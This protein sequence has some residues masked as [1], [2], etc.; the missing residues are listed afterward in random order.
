MNSLKYILFL[1]MTS[2]TVISSTPYSGP[3]SDHFNGKTFENYLKDP[4]KKSFW[5]FVKMKYFDD[6]WP[7]WPTEFDKVKPVAPD[8]THQAKVTFINHATLLIQLDHQNILTDPIWS[9]RASPFS[10]AGPARVTEPG[11]KKE[12]LPKIDVIL[13]SHNHY[14][15]LD[16]E[17]LKYLSK[18]DRPLILIGLGNDVLL[19]ENGI[20]NVKTLDW[21]E[22]IEI[23]EIKY[24]FTPSQHWSARGLRDRNQTLWG[25]FWIEGSKKIYFAGDTGFG[26]HF[27]MIKS[28]LG[29]PDL[30]LLPIG[31]YEP[32]WFM[33]Y[34]HM[35]P[36][37]ALDT[38]HLLDAKTSIGIHFGT[39]RL[40]KEPYDAPKKDL[41]EAIKND[42][43]KDDSKFYVPYN[44]EQFLF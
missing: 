6:P 13:I 9:N 1:L 43:L 42:P 33:R 44:G 34:A 27:H 15:H 11:V 30:A 26:P 22:S 38:H 40:T 7:K 25:S 28:R 37:E 2:C 36:K 17:S 29:S 35:N 3:K 16:L 18:R 39:F 21:W 41:L 31:A 8:K 19:K 20:E 24:S 12:D 23:E 5:R 10:F 4:G 32:R 14:D